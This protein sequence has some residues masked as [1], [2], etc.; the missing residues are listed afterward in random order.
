MPTD[1]IIVTSLELDIPA[2]VKA[3][4]DGVVGSLGNA[5]LVLKDKD[6]FSYRR[7]FPG[8][9]YSDLPN[10]IAIVLDNDPWCAEISSDISRTTDN[11]VIV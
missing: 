9:E 11:L 4:E 1:F 6:T 10:S 3:I 8:D 7:W 5:G 2:F